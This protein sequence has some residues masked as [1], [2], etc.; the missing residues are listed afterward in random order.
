MHDRLRFLNVFPPPDIEKDACKQFMGI[1][2]FSLTML[3]SKLLD[4]IQIE[5]SIVPRCADIFAQSFSERVG[6][7]ETGVEVRIEKLSSPE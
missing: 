5:D 6:S 4:K 3:P 7:V 2:A 1:V